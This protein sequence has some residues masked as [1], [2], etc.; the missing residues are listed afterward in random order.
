MTSASQRPVILYGVQHENP[1]FACSGRCREPPSSGLGVS[2]PNF[3]FDRDLRIVQILGDVQFHA[4]LRCSAGWGLTSAQSSAKSFFDPK[5]GAASG[6]RPA[7][8]PGLALGSVAR[9]AD[10]STVVTR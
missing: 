5:L 1:T 8:Q 10:S 9:F 3:G 7:C 4:T 6:L 2:D